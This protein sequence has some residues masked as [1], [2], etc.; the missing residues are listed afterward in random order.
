MIDVLKTAGAIVILIG[1]L[2]IAF[3]QPPAHRHRGRIVGVLVQRVL[4]A[5]GR[6]AKVLPDVIQVRQQEKRFFMGFG[7][8]LGFHEIEILL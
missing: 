6:E 4:I 3:G 5:Q 2:A 1:Q 7:I 8:D